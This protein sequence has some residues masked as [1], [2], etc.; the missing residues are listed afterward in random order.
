MWNDLRTDAYEGMIGEI[1]TIKGYNGD[2]IHSYFSRPVGS[3]PY[4]GIVLVHHL[5]GWDEFYRETARRFTQ[6]GYVVICP[7]LYERFGHGSPEEMAAAARAEGGV[8]DDSVIGD[9]EEALNYLRSLP[10]SN[11]KVGIIGT[12]SG[13]RHTF[14][15]ACRVNGFDAAV[16]C[17][18]GNVV[19]PANRLTPQQ[20]VAPLDYTRDLSCPLLGL[21][22]NDDQSPSPDQVNQH[23][24]ELQRHGKNYDF[25]RYDGAGHGFWYYDRQNY[26]PEQA[27]DA[28]QKVFSFFAQHFQ[29]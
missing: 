5:P 10:Y 27:M 24:A 1:I 9:S 7:N 11:G 4:P 8:P 28:W 2:R 16:D 26:R 25:H 15:V 20:P 17:W 14:L 21:F 19:Q 13:G 23:E 12:C 29:G 18:G 3:G 6:H 22:G